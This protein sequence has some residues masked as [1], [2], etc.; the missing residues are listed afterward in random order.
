[1]TCTAESSQTPPTDGLVL[2][3][4]TDGSGGSPA[5]PAPGLLMVTAPGSLGPTANHSLQ[6]PRDLVQVRWPQCP[7]SRA[8]GTRTRPDARHHLRG[9]PRGRLTDDVHRGAPAAGPALP[10]RP[11]HRPGHSTPAHPCGDQPAA[12]GFRGCCF[13]GRERGLPK[14]LQPVHFPRTRSATSP[15]S[16]TIWNWRRSRTPSAR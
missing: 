13:A 9:Q 6:H 5:A 16:R 14:P 10:R 11:E 4:W 7:P 1:M 15:R 8:A 2:G 12:A 3:F